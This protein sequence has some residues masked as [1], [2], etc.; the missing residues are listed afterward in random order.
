MRVSF[1]VGCR[2]G[3]GLVAG[4]GPAW[5]LVVSGKAGRFQERLCGFRKCRVVSGEAVWS[6]ESAMMF[7]V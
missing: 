7:E 2:V 4:L 3:L 5:G 1:R 6:H